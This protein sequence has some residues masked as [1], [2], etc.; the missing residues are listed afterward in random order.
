[1]K[2]PSPA[3]SA[4]ASACAT[5]LTAALALAAGCAGDDGPPPAPTPPAVDDLLLEFDAIDGVLD[6]DAA[7]DLVDG[8]LGDVVTLAAIGVLMAELDTA[9]GELDKASGTSAQSESLTA[10]MPPAAASG[11]QGPDRA[12]PPV[13]QR[14]YALNVAAGSWARLTHLCPGTDGSVADPANGSIVLRSV[15]DLLTIATDGLERVVVW[16]EASDCLLASEEGLATLDADITGAMELTGSNDLILSLVGQL[17]TADGTPSGFDLRLQQTDDGYA[18]LR[19][20]AG[21]GTFLVG[22]RVLDSSVTEATLTDV[23][24]VW[25]C[26][27]DADESTGE[28]SRDGEV[29]AWP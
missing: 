22:V 12:A 5:A 17:V 27:F 15:F 8:A 26:T 21:N 20:V 10:R 28:C 29:F 9:A 24:G 4:R 14:A 23:D 19:E 13:S 25:V 6:A 2:R 18:L 11:A 1:M 16:G 7:R 3:R